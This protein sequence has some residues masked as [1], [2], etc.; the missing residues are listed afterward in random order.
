MDDIE[1][2]FRY[3]V[4]PVEVFSG[5]V[6]NL[7]VIGIWMFG[8]KSKLLC[9]ANYFSANAALDLLNLAF[10]GL[11]YVIM[12]FNIYMLPNTVTF[13]KV[14]VFT[15]YAFQKCSNW[16]SAAVTVERS[17]TILLPFMFNPRKMRKRSVYVIIALVFIIML[18]NIQ[19]TRQFRVSIEI[20]DAC[21]F[22]RKV[23]RNKSALIVQ[24]IVPPYYDK[25]QE[26]F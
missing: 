23:W 6:T 11:V 9:C 8:A 12:N 2:G 3:V 13:C 18:A 17:L 1:F 25:I 26:F 10:P 5:I 16:I 4:L 20:N 21:F 15:V 14:Y 24:Q 19:L 7:I 22:K